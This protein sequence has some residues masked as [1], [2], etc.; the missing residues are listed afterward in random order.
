[1]CANPCAR[2]I[3]LRHYVRSDSFVACASLGGGPPRSR[4]T[5]AGSGAPVTGGHCSTVEHKCLLVYH[6]SQ[7]AHHRERS[8]ETNS[9]GYIP[10]WV[11]GVRYKFSEMVLCRPT[12]FYVSFFARDETTTRR[13]PRSLGTPDHLVS[14]CLNMYSPRSIRSCHSSLFGR[15]YNRFSPSSRGT[16]FTAV[17]RNSNSRHHPDLDQY[18]KQ[19]HLDK[20][21]LREV[22]GFPLQCRDTL[23]SG[24]IFGNLLRA[25]RWLSWIIRNFLVPERC[26]TPG[27]Y[28]GMLISKRII[29]L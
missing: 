7:R 19:H 21:T 12:L 27:Y 22:Q 6:T 28:T 20:D 10:A 3:K 4:G 8:L 29:V 14:V 2:S 9:Q 11:K 17:P 1:M 18:L 15:S 13:E 26:S 5:S 16:S 25:S 24:M 23:R